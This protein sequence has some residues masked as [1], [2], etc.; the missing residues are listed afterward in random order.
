MRDAA[1]IT[2]G[3]YE[4]GHGLAKALGNAA[5]GVLRTRPMLHAESTDLFA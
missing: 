2:H 4:H 5:E 1:W 3:Q